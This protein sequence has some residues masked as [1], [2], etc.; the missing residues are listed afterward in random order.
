MIDAI[1]AVSGKKKKKVT[2][3]HLVVPEPISPKW[4]GTILPHHFYKLI[5]ESNNKVIETSNK[6]FH[7]Q[8]KEHQERSKWDH[9]MRF[10]K[11]IANNNFLNNRLVLIPHS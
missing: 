8:Q 6:N 4:I 1:E 10:K 2:P 11:R 7:M 5:S 3:P 9:L